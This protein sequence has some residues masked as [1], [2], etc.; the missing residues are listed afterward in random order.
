MQSTQT[1]TLPI[2][3]L[4]TTARQAHGFP[5]LASGSLLS[6]GQFCDHQ[7]TA[8]FTST[9]AHVYAN[10]D[11]QIIPSNQ[12]IITATRHYPD[13]LWST[14]IPPT[15]PPSRIPSSEQ[16]LATIN[17]PTLTD[18][19][20]FY[21]ASLFSPTIT[22]W[23]KA[24][25]NGHLDTWPALTPKQITR[26]GQLTEATVKGHLHA[27]RSNIQST[28][29]YINPTLPLTFAASAANV[30]IIS[31]PQSDSNTRTNQVYVNISEPTGKI[32]SDQTGKFL[33]PSRRGN[34]YILIVYD[35]DSNMIFAEPL[36][37]RSK[38]NLTA[39]YRTI[40]SLLIAR[41]LKPTLAKMDNEIS[42]S[43]KTMLAEHEIDYELTPAGLHRRN[44]AERA[45]Q[46]FKNH[47]I[48]GLSSTHPDF[49]LNLWD[50]LIPQCVI[51]LNLLRKSRLHPHLSAYSHVN[52]PFN[53]ARTPL[54][55]PGM[56]V[57]LHERPA[58]RGSFDS[59]AIPGW[60]LGPAMKHY[61][62]YKIWI[63]QTNSIRILDQVTW[64][65]HKRP[66][67]T[68]SKA[69]LVIA[70]AK[71]LTSALL[72]PS[73]PNH[74]LPPLDTVTRKALLDL[75][76]IFA[77]RVKPQDNIILSSN[78][79]PKESAEI[80]RVPI[81]SPATRPRVPMY[82]PPK[83]TQ[84][85]LLHNNARKSLRRKTIPKKQP[86]KQIP[87]RSTRTRT[88]NPKFQAT[89]LVTSSYSP[90]LPSKLQ[91]LI[92]KELDRPSFPN[93]HSP[94]LAN[95]VL[96]PTTGKLL[97]YRDLLKTK[98]KDKWYDACSKEFARLCQG[99]SKDNTASTNTIFFKHPDE[100]PNNKKATYLRICAN[101]R[102][103]KADPYRVRFTVGGNLVDYKGV[104]YTPTADLT[105]AKILINSV[106]S[107]PDAQLL[108]L[109]LSNFYLI[110]PF[111]D[112]SEYEYMWIPAWV[113]PA[114]IMKE[115]N[116]ENKIKNGKILAEI[117]T[118][119]YGLPQAGRMAYKKL[120]KHLASYGYFPTGHTPGLFKH[121]TRP[122][123][124]CLVVDDFGAK[125]VG[126]HHGQHLIDCL[127][128]HYDITIDWD[129]SIFCGV[130]LTWDYEKRTCDLHMPN[131]VRKAAQRFTVP[132]PTTPQHSPHPWT[133]PTYGSSV[134]LTPSIDS[135]PKPT[136]AQTK[137]AQ[138]VIGTFLYYAR[139][140]DNTMLMPIGSIATALSTSSWKQIEHRINHFL[141][142]AV[143]H[144]DARIRYKASA[145]HLWIHS[146]S[147]YLNE[148]K[149][150]S[151][152]AGYFH[153]SDVPQ[154]PI[155]PTDPPPPLNAPIL[156][157]SKVIPNV[158]SSA[159]E[160]ETGM[161]FLNARDAIPIRQTLQ[162]MGH[163]QGPTPI[164]FDNIV[165]TGIINDTVTQRRSKAMDM[166]F[167]WLRDRAA[168]KQFH[169]HWK[170][171]AANLADYPTKHHST[172]HHISVRPTY[173]LNASLQNMNPVTS[174][175]TPNVIARVC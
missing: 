5:H 14:Q 95:A 81:I 148:P 68:S 122:V 54:A 26:Y 38:Q 120:V 34:K 58:D 48:A 171:G 166:R 124:F 79:Q 61:R 118:G 109:D 121:L 73:S 53:Y 87:R 115:Y 157:N 150:R 17:Q 116:L 105:T 45:I 47:F 80:P 130:H 74:I 76:K 146:D 94:E 44:L 172:K 65:P 111:K 97:E 70:S 33:C 24:V 167:Y 173:V 152:G 39:A 103:Q 21:H 113:I 10:K 107:T 32:F 78:S 162:E 29:K 18:R 139:A 50:D 86:S 125:I 4:P 158:M 23:I 1:A 155:K 93:P 72:L 57:L 56:K 13:K 41:G 102:P 88:P 31:S 60:Y 84:D 159:A 15:H 104:T 170:R 9:K 149:A 92:N 69:D 22:T 175:V 12:P 75:N 42:D 126:R 144:P 168:Q 91:H 154:L 101:Y 160:A 35:Y 151:R 140:V 55:P 153:L 71:D 7:C 136:P 138:E 59:H 90:Q 141:H 62:C 89:N 85:F 16:A 99:R 43:I 20:T 37:N 52:G 131:Y 100:L 132:K 142:Y 19:L 40:I 117:R 25:Q 137:Y 67:P 49:P 128:N 30:S 106:L 83:T 163:P 174:N 3:Q 133:P 134:Q 114:D 63:P 123:L 164:Q 28:S 145:M 119:M 129:G 51:T 135:D 11:I 165:A 8:I 169:I 98:D 46:T 6:I 2:P 64:L 161:G 156:V 147:S 143:T 112:P 77:D 108:G 82:Q 36:P 110:T 96:D 127:K 27:K 66:M